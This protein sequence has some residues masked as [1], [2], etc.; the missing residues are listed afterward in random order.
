M[1]RTDFND[2]IKPYSPQR[3]KERKVVLLF[4]IMDIFAN[5]ASLR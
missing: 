2:A 5:F 3:R 4:S 1:A